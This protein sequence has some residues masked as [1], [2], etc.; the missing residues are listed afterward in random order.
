[1]KDPSQS[2]AGAA[3]TEIIVAREADIKAVSVNRTIST[4][5]REVWE[6]RA[7]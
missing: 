5:Y 1:M 6:K 2:P 3:G 7:S 4:C